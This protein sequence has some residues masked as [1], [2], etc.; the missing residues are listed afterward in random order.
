MNYIF[1]R[2]NNLQVAE[3][4]TAEV[5]VR[6]VEKYDLS[7]FSSQSVSSW[8]YTTARNLI[9]DYL[10]KGENQFTF[11]QEK[12][13]MVDKDSSIH[14]KVEQRLNHEMLAQAMQHLTADQT[15]V[16]LLKFIERKSNAEVAK[17][18]GKSEGAIKSLQF[19][20]LATLRRALERE[21]IYDA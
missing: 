2:L 16:I 8:L 5:F 9:V 12:V 7:R 11:H 6:F 18:L 10:R 1:H 13:Q 20:A 15:Q 21:Q 14:S 3:D 19:R 17:M 4:L